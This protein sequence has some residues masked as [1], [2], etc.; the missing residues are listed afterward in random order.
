[1]ELLFIDEGDYRDLIRSDGL[2]QLL[3][4][5]AKGRDIVRS[6]ARQIVKRNRDH[7]VDGSFHCERPPAGETNETNKRNGKHNS[8]HQVTQSYSAAS[9]NSS[10]AIVCRCIFDVPS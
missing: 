3:R 10:L 6:H 7:T 8:L 2:Q 4:Q 9:A 5:L 1:M